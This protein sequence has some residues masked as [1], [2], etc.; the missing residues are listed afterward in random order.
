MV[1]SVSPL[2]A[3]FHA[4]SF[5]MVYMRPYGIETWDQFLDDLMRHW[6]TADPHT[7]VDLLR[8]NNARERRA[9][10]DCASNGYPAQRACFSSVF[11]DSGKE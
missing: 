10:C 7:Y 6:S 2:S 11:K 4:F 8:E 9:N 5:L 1:P 3:A